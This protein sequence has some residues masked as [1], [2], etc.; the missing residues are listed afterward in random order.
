M[1]KQVKQLIITA[2]LIV[3]L[4]V[5]IAGNLKKKPFK[6][7]VPVSSGV[8]A[9]AV[10]KSPAATPVSF[11]PADERRLKMQ[12]ERANLPWG[13]SPFKSSTDK[14][15]QKTDLELKGISLGKDKKNFAFINNDI[16]KVGDK[17]ADYEVVEI[18]KDRVLL[19]KGDQGFYLTLPQ[20]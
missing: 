1:T 10:A 5:V 6:K 3:V 16:V 8:P 4:V 15:Y 11:I 7:L 20:E 14:D 13:K 12:K 18:Q 19:K 17:V 2:S 9:A